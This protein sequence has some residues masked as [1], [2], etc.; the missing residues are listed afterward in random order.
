MLD[1][2]IPYYNIIMKRNPGTPVPEPL[3]PE[4]YMFVPYCEGD[5]KSWAEIETSVGE[6]DSIPEALEYFNQNPSNP[7][8]KNYNCFYLEGVFIDKTAVCDGISKAF[9]LL[10]RM[11]GIECY[12]VT[13]T[14]RGVGHA[15]NKIVINGKVYVVDATWGDANNNN[16]QYLMHSY[17]MISDVEAIEDHTEKNMTVFA[18]SGYDIYSSKANDHLYIANNDSE[19]TTLINSMTSNTYAIEVWLKYNYGNPP[20]ANYGYTRITNSGKSVLIIR[21]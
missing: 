19:L 13:G 12:R 21:S 16:N 2:S 7:D 8:L 15:W 18:E 1:K 20:S 11:E 6:F 3:L 10:C 14:S 9:S 4:G 17:F 5:E